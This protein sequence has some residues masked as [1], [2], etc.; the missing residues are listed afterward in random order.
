MMLLE[1]LA[2]HVLHHDEEHVVLLLGGEHRDD[3]R[4]AHRG[5][6]PRLLQ[7]LAEVEVLL[8][9]DLERDLLVDPGVFG[10]VDA[11]EA[12]A[13][14]GRQDAVLADGLTAEEHEVMRSIAGASVDGEDR[15]PVESHGERA[16]L[17][18]RRARIGRR[19]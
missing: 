14:E 18:A 2:R 15:A 12:A 17:C 7:H 3:V 10:Q 19:S 9:R 1:R 8:V 4:M 13:A 6:Q 16:I 11:A 5:E